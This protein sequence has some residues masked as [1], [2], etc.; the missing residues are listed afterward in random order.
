[1]VG[2]FHI[3]SPLGNITCN[4]RKWLCSLWASCFG[5]CEWNRTLQILSIWLCWLCC[6]WRSY[7]DGCHC[8]FGAVV[9][10]VTQEVGNCHIGSYNHDSVGEQYPRRT[11]LT[12]RGSCRNKDQIEQRRGCSYWYLARSP[13]VP[14]HMRLSIQRRTL[15][16]VHA[17]RCLGLGGTW[18]SVNSYIH[19]YH[20]VIF[21]KGRWTCFD[22]WART[23]LTNWW[24][25]IVDD[26]NSSDG[27]GWWGQTRV[28]T[29]W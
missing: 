27:N 13:C 18:T 29:S 17:L 23:A 1:M 7:H 3:P 20:M 15:K 25:M 19:I 16:G 2:M 6:H 4:Q 24:L 8:C 5:W 11:A 9:G 21:S 12:W 14:L 26:H 22:C 10:C 28:N